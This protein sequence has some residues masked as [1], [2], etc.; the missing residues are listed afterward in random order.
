MKHFVGQFVLRFAQAQAVLRFLRS[1][2][3]QAASRNAQEQ[4]DFLLSD[5]CAPTKEVVESVYVASGSFLLQA[6]RGQILL[7]LL[8]DFLL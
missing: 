6:F 4:A 2:G 3:A 1:V 5:V 8:L 7:S